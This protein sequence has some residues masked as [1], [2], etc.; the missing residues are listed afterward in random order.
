VVANRISRNPPRP[1]LSACTKAPT[2][3]NAGIGSKA[4]LIVV[5]SGFFWADHRRA[6]R[7]RAWTPRRS[8]LDNLEDKAISLI[9]RP[10]YEAFIRGY[11]IK[12]WQVN[13]V[14]LELF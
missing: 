5:G 14:R 8:Q 3:G 12:Q 9:G 7:S 2:S 4:D 1:G 13:P 11:T 6:R 10:L